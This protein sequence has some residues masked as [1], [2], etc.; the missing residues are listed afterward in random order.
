MNGEYKRVVAVNKRASFEY[1]IEEKFEAGI[2]LLGSEVKSIR[3]GKI[4]I[5]DS[6]AAYSGSELILYNC[7]IAEYAEANRFNHD[8]RRPKKLLLKAKEIKKIIGKIK[9]KGYTLIALSAY[10]NHKNLVKIELGLAK[11]KKLYDKRQTLK[12]N[13]WKR[14]QAR[15]IRD[16]NK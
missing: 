12:E 5:A 13:D 7:H 2:V 3:Q 14:E 8:T 16:K 9:L 1:F 15:L 6:H 4:N 11:G 10:F